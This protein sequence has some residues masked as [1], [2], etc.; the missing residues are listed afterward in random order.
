MTDKPIADTIEHPRF[1]GLW[2]YRPY[3][4][5]R[6]FCATVIVDGVVNETEMFDEW[7]DALHAAGR[8]LVETE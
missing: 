2:T 3:G 4:G 8:V 6:K 1:C 7:R 5:R